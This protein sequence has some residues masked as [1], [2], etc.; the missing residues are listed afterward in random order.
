MDETKGT[1]TTGRSE[2]YRRTKEMETGSGKE[3]RS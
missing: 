3:S 2:S 1:A